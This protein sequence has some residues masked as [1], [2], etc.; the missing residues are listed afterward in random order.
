MIKRSTASLL[1]C[2]LLFISQLALSQQAGTAN[3]VVH[4]DLTASTT[5]FPHFWEQMF[6]SGRANLTLRDSYRRDLDWTREITAFKYVRFHAIFQDENGVYDEDAQ[7]NPVYNFSHFY[8]I[9]NGLLAYRVNPIVD[10]SF[11]LKKLTPRP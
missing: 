10:I 11:I 5:P 3:E 6:G 1:L 7:G 2:C 4:V 9:Y 8:Q